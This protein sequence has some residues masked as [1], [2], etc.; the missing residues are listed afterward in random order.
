MSVRAE[1]EHHVTLLLNEPTKCKMHIIEAEK[2]ELTER[3]N[4]SLLLDSAS[5]QRLLWSV[6][7]KSLTSDRIAERYKLD[8]RT[9][10]SKKSKYIFKN[11]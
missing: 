4:L 6:P 5:H 1:P 11:T 8:D 10:E 9:I 7:H 3:S 2:K